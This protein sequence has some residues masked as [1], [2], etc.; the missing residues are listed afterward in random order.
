[1]P[2]GVRRGVAPTLPRW[3]VFL[4][5][6]NGLDTVLG[7]FQAL[8]GM[9]TKEP[10][11]FCEPGQ[12]HEIGLTRFYSTVTVAAESARGRFGRRSCQALLSRALLGSVGAVN[13]HNRHEQGVLPRALLSGRHPNGGATTSTQL[14]SVIG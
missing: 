14:K 4:S 10:A 12:T 5:K 7:Y 9:R 2:T 13:L 3:F 1:M 6:F 8:L 11:T